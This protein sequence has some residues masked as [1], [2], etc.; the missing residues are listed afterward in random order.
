MQA[1]AEQ[2]RDLAAQGSP[3]KFT[4][5]KRLDCAFTAAKLY[6]MNSTTAALMDSLPSSTSSK[7]FLATLH[8]Q[9][10]GLTEHAEE[11]SQNRL[12]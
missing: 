9:V 10:V 7:N 11:R 2:H 3:N 4:S 12:C 8:H 1:A 6:G 5:K